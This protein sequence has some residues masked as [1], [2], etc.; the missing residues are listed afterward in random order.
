[1]NEARDQAEWFSGGKVFAFCAK[2]V[3]RVF[4]EQGKGESRGT[5]TEAAKVVQAMV[6]AV[7]GVRRDLVLGVF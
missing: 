7:E 5:S 4:P 6:V 3:C 1:M 2:N